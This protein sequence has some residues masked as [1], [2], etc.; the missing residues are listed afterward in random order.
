MEY[1]NLLK[2][3]NACRSK[4]ETRPMLLDVYS[5]GKSLVATNGCVLFGVN[6]TKHK[7]GYYLI[8]EKTSDI[9]GF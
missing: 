8:N 4:D 3:L 5:D 6:N 7:Q 1:K 2:C 9:T